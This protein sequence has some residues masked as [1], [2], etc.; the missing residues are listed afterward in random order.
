[1]GGRI[2]FQLK[3]VMELQD[4]KGKR[5]PEI[6]KEDGAIIPAKVML[7]IIK[8]YGDQFY[9]DDVQEKISQM[10]EWAKKFDMK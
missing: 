4:N 6:I 8:K 7:E 1:M 5:C 3:C 2:Y 10:D 9:I